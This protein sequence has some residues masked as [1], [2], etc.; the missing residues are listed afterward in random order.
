MDHATRGVGLDEGRVVL[1]PVRA[2]GFFFSVEVVQVAEE[3]VETVVGRQVFIL[4][5]QVVLAELAGGVALGLE[6]L[7]N[8]DVT[9]LQTH[10]ST[11]DADFRQAGAQWCLASDKR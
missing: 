6:C 11:R 10:R 4:V 8:G 3:L 2:L 5:A 1:G 7:G 9:L